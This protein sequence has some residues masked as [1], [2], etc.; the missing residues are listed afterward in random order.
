MSVAT[1][2]DTG[3]IACQMAELGKR[4]RAV[5]ELAGG[6][7]TQNALHTAAAALRERT[8]NLLAANEGMAAARFSKHCRTLLTA[9]LDATR[10]DAMAPDWNR[11]RICPIP[12]AKFWPTGTVPMA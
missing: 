7:R 11:S 9:L 1:A 5:Y 10:I 2:I 8:D 12:W 3:D 6:Q 4:A